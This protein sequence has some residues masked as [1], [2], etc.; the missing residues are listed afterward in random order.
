MGTNRTRGKN[1]QPDKNQFDRGEQISRDE[2]H[3]QYNHAKA[4]VVGLGQGM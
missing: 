3:T 4:N 2:G 1:K